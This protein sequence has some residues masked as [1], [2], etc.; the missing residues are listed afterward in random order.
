DVALL[1]GLMHII[2]KE[3]WEAKEFI[4]DRTENFEQLKEVV[5]KYTPERVAEITGV[6]NESL[7][8]AAE[9]YA[10]SKKAMIV[11]AM[12]I[13]QHITGTDNVKS[14]AN[15]AMLTGHVGYSSTGVNPL[16]GQ[17][18]VQGACDMGALPNVYTGYQTV[19]AP[20]TREKFEKEWGVN[21]LNDKIG[22]TVTEMIDAAEIGQIK[23]LY[24]MGENPVVSDADARH[25]A[26]ALKRLDFL[27]VQDIFMTETARLAHV[28]LPAASFAEKT[29][30]FTNTERRVQLSGEAIAPLEGVRPDWKIICDISSRANYP[31]NYQSPIEILDEIN[32]VT[33]SYGGITYRRLKDSWGLSWPCPNE[34]HPGTQFLHE[35]QFTRGLGFFDAREY[36]PPAEA[37]DEEYP[38]TLITGRVGF[39]Y[40]TGTMS[41]KISILEREAPKA[42]LEMNPKDARRVRVRD[43]GIVAIESRRGEL[44]LP[45]VVTP[46]IPEGVVF[47]TFHYSEN[48]INELT[49]NA[50]DPVAKIPEFSCAV[51]I[52]RI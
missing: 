31:M 27:V 18:N 7:R 16:R 20:N 30:T 44:H 35:N 36:M 2:L 13:T 25:V 37:P 38:F 3:G 42:V 9:I 47:S 6:D 29:G 43:G 28:V 34:D 32:R 10:S 45:V 5:A 33:P 46:D 23:A 52:R 19:T 26:R 1:N 22:L 12:G 8:K 11:Y 51:S 4:K 40:H 17:N 21:D 39:Q 15:L 14:C 48:N 24:I 41:R 49:I 50:L